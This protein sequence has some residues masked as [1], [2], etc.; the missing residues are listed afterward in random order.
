MNLST[1]TNITNELTGLQ[2]HRLLKQSINAINSMYYDALGTN[3]WPQ[4]CTLLIESESLN[5][6]N[7]DREFAIL[8]QGIC[9]YFNEIYEPERPYK[10]FHIQAARSPYMPEKLVVH[11]K[12]GQSAIMANQAQGLRH[13]TM[14]QTVVK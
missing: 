3:Q 1:C 6:N 7:Y 13:I 14:K 10:K 8:S 11:L 2:R 9:E 12:W 5:R 4:E